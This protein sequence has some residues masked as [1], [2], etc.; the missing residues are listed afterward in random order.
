MRSD[1]PIFLKRSPSFF[2]LLSEG[3]M[4][5]EAK[6]LV[7]GRHSVNKYLLRK[8]AHLKSTLKKSLKEK[9]ADS[10]SAI[11]EFGFLFPNDPFLEQ[12]PNPKLDPADSLSDNLRWVVFS[13]ALAIVL[14]WSLEFRDLPLGEKNFKPDPVKVEE[15]KKVPTPSRP[16]EKPKVVVKPYG[17]V[18]I[19]A[20]S[21]VN[22]FIDGKEVSSHRRIKLPTGERSLVLKKRGFEDIKSTIIVK[23]DQVV[24]VNVGGDKP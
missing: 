15:I 7:M 18:Q 23:P 10:L 24:T 1:C 5:E 14:L 8:S 12:V 21:G 19:N 13:V 20:V 11:N 9:K 3:K 16:L 17:W 4:V 22:I 2:Q 6:E